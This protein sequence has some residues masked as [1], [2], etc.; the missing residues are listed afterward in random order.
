MI[1]S[2]KMFK[3]IKRNPA[4]KSYLWRWRTFRFYWGFPEHI[5]DLIVVFTSPCAPKSVYCRSDHFEH[6]TQLARARPRMTS[7][8]TSWGSNSRWSN[9]CRI[10]VL[11]CSG[12]SLCV[13]SAWGFV[14]GHKNDFNFLY[15]LCLFPVFPVHAGSDRVVF[16]CEKWRLDW[17]CVLTDFDCAVDFI[18]IYLCWQNRILSG[19][20]SLLETKFTLLTPSRFDTLD[21]GFAF[22]FH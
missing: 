17:Y 15:E 16:W 22:H 6:K 14:K 5:V 11:F 7:W 2:F 1:I 19:L 9:I 8:L 18:F 12:I 4:V 3:G 10:N 21:F 13:I 20:S